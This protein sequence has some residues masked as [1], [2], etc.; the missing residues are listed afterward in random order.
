MKVFMFGFAFMV[1]AFPLQ[2]QTATHPKI[3][4]PSPKQIQA[5]GDSEMRHL[6]SL[7]SINTTSEVNKNKTEC[8]LDKKTKQT[9]CHTREE[10]N[11][12]ASETQSN[13]AN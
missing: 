2:A 3:S 7:G 12:I 11:A 8:L 13:P 9:V 10:W 1:A 4:Y 6:R 5:A